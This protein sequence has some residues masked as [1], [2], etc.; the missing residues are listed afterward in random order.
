M[1]HR[2]RIKLRY[3]RKMGKWLDLDNPV[4]F[5]EKLQWLKA[6]DL[7]PYYTD[8]V[9]KQKVKEIISEKIGEEHIIPTIAIYERPEDIKWEDL[10]D[11]FVLKCTHDS[12]GIVVCQDKKSIDKAAALKKLTK[13]YNRNYYYNKREWPYK[14]IKPRI[15]AEQYME[16]REGEGELK[17]YK[18]F[19]FNG[20]PKMLFIASDRHKKVETKFDFF[21]MDFNH[22]D[23]RQ[24]HPNSEILPEK[25]ETFEQMKEMAA[26]LSEGFPHVRVD[27]YEI[28]GK[29]YFGEL[30]LYHYSGTVPFDPVKW[31]TTMGEWITLPEKRV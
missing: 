29:I 23:I 2:F 15:I 12:G 3:L 7:N 4:T 14:N 19:C 20:V 13:H 16:D 1:Y 9:D 22:L 30:T 21:D 8:I 11:R 5:N 27:L 17:D 6:Y 10:P 28:N 18:F 31:D 24:G 26:K 25:P